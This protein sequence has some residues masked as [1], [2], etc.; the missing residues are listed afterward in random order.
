M[1][2]RSGN[3]RALKAWARLKSSVEAVVPKYTMLHTEYGGHAK[4]L[5]SK[6]LQDG[7]TRIVSCG[8]DGTHNEVANGF[9]QNDQARNPDASMAIVP[10]GTGCDLGRSLRLPKPEDSIDYIADPQTTAMDVGKL[11]C[12]GEDGETVENYFLIA[13]HAGLGGHLNMQVN[14]RTKALGGFLTF[15]L[16]VIT[17]RL[18]Y[19]DPEMTVTIDGETITKP[20]MDIIMANGQYDGGGMHIGPKTLLNNGHLEVYTIDKLNFLGVLLN[21]PRIY[22]GTLEEH[23]KVTY[24]RAKKITIESDEKVWISPDG[25]V[26]G[27][28]PATVKVISQSINMVMGPNPPLV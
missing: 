2:P 13:A 9:F 12:V 26:S 14:N 25:E 27:V 19:T 22:N 8:G 28:L 4:E 16:G 5:A 7:Y 6:A 17:A 3:G 20:F 15:L 21:I 24:Y 1:N 10:F 23:P 11:Q 18:T